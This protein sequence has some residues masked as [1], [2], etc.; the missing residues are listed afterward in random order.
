MA[1]T[2]NQKPLQ[3]K[4]FRLRRASLVAAS[5]VPLVKLLILING[6]VLALRVQLMFK[7]LGHTHFLMRLPIITVKPLAIRLFNRALIGL[8]VR[9]VCLGKQKVTVALVVNLALLVRHLA[10]RILGSQQWTGPLAAKLARLVPHR[11][12]RRLGRLQVTEP[13]AVR[14]AHLVLRLVLRRL[15]RLLELTYL[16]LVSLIL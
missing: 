1:L 5:Q 3:T 10:L 6:Q 4:H 13:S 14:P 2:R 9:R 12:L 16:T 8:K 7:N 15:L 11:V